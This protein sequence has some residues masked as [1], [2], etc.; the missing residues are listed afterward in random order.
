MASNVN[1]EEQ[2]AK[3]RFRQDL[4]YRLNVMTF[5][6][7][8]LRNRCQDI[9]LLTRAIVARNNARFGKALFDISPDAL[10]ALEAYHWP[11]NVRQLENVLQEA[12]LVSSGPE[13][14]LRDLPQ[15]VTADPVAEQPDSSSNGVATAM[16]AADTP[17][18]SPA[19]R[20]NQAEPAETL[21]GGRATY[22][23]GLIQRTL[24][25]CNQNRSRAARSL[26]ISRVTLYKKLKLYQ[27]VDE[28]AR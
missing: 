6:L 21:L 16:I 27:L 20:C 5:H 12:V 25:E 26:G 11:G 9:P 4:Y 8:P 17:T 23:R 13:L 22:E 28:A 18:T 10:A 1:L 24:V 3:G 19:P 2:V 15:L 7:P 14:L